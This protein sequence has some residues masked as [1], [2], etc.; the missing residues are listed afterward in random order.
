[1]G[2]ENYQK[3]KD[4]RQRYGREYYWLHREKRLKQNKEWCNKNKSRVR[5]RKRLV[6]NTDVRD[7]LFRYKQERGLRCAI[8]GYN[9]NWSALIWH[10]IEE[11]T[12]EINIATYA[13]QRRGWTKVEEEIQKCVLLC[14][15]CHSELH[16]PQ[17]KIL[18]NA[19]PH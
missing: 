11:G 19:N 12:K 13:R 3:N 9:K 8:C 17:A 14:H 4:A 18:K 7:R 2:K 1:M 5:N 6:Y 16:Y 15:N 10:H